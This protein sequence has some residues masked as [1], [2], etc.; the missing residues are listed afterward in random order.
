M[1]EPQPVSACFFIPS[2][3]SLC[4]KLIYVLTE[5]LVTSFCFQYLSPLGLIVTQGIFDLCL[6]MWHLVPWPGIE[7]R[8]PA[9]GGQSLSH[10]T[11]REVPGHLLA[12]LKIRATASSSSQICCSKATSVYSIS[13]FRIL[14][15]HPALYHW[16]STGMRLFHMVTRKSPEFLSPSKFHLKIGHFLPVLLKKRGKSKV[17]DPGSLVYKK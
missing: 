6:G 7:P 11:T 3:N 13:H 15:Y 9:L 8:P 14:H 17:R 5:L 16:V 2:S 1:C 4:W 12:V 10:W